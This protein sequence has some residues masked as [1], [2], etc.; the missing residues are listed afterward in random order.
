[1]QTLLCKADQTQ[2]YQQL[3]MTLSEIA[4]Y[5]LISQQIAEP[6]FESANEMVAWLAAVQAQEYAHT[7]WSLGLRLPHLKD[8]DIE[9]EF[10]DGR[11]LRTHLLR[12]TW[13]F[14]T[15]EDIRWMLTLTAPRVNAVNS[16]MYRKCNLDNAT[17]KRCNNILIKTLQGG[18]QLTRGA[19][20]EEF[21]KNKIIADGHRLSYIMMRA[22]LD[23]I[24][25]SGSRKGNQ[26]TYALLD[27]RVPLSNSKDQDEALATLTNRYFAS[28]GPATVQDFSTWSGLTLTDCKR[29]ITIVKSHFIQ[30]Q[31][32]NEDYY[33]SAHISLNEMQFQ[34]ICLLPLYDEFIMG[35]KDRK[36]IFQLR[37]SIKPAPIFRF[38]NTIILEGQ[39]CGTWKRTINKKS[40]DLEYDFFKPL[41]QRHF[42][43]FEK[44]VDRLGQFTNLTVNYLK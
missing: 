32:D 18:K 21:K 14:V 24:I 11:I 5:R 16:F 17:F 29:G 22:E 34:Y 35:Y 3:L 12:P 9:K 4:K 6:K 40:I 15:A 23:G 2:L 8:D 7:K 10:S 33:F 20:N 28:R 39:I 19:L 25:C 41:T 38:D 37:N 42:K 44:A 31:I 30:E 43:A 13:H 27:E 26:F 1:L 36:A